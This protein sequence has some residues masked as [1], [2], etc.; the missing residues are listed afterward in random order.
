MSS[1]TCNKDQLV[2]QPAIGLP[3]ELGRTTVS[4]SGRILAAKKRNPEAETPALAA[5]IDRHVYAL[6]QPSPRLRLAGGLTADEVKLVEEA[7]K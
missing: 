7:S 3:A 4:A 1:H 2:E 5:E 6:Y